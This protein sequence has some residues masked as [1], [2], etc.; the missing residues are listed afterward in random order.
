[1]VTATKERSAT[2]ERSET[3]LVTKIFIN[4]ERFESDLLNEGETPRTC[5]K[6]RDLVPNLKVT[7]YN[8]MVKV[9]I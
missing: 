3:I 8:K 9:M 2:E 6:T 1:M 5:S 7:C 4:M